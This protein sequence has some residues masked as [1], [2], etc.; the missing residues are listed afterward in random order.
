MTG[1]FVSFKEASPEIA[2][3]F[4]WTETRA[5]TLG[6]RLARS[7]LPLEAVARWAAQMKIVEREAD[8][9]DLR[10]RLFGTGMVDIYGRDLTGQKLR[11]VLPESVAGQM[12]AGYARAAEG[13]VV[14]EN[15]RFDLGDGKSVAYE[16]LIYPL[17]NEGAFSLFAVVGYRMSGERHFLFAREGIRHISSELRVL[18]AG[19]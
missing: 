3:F 14:Y 15:V 13:A 17:D 6:C 16:R 7:D 8:T 5:Q 11:D 2:A 1:G 18:V 12:L 19:G 4:A 10:V 9:G